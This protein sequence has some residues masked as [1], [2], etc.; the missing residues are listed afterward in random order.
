MFDK[1]KL[2]GTDTAIYGVSTI[3]GRFLTFLLTPIYANILPPSD[4]GIV[5]T[6]YAYIA[7]LS[8]LYT[9]GMESAYL[10]YSSTLELGNQKQTFTIPCLSLLVTSL[11]F[12]GLILLFPHPVAEA[13]HLP[14]SYERVVL[15]A[16]AILFLDAVVI[17][18]FAHLRM[19]RKAKMFATI[20]VVNIVINVSLNILFLVKYNLGV[21]G[22]FL[23][24]LL[25]SASSVVM[26]LPTIISNVTVKLP[27][28]LYGALLRFGLPYVPAGLATMMI[29]VVDRPILES[30]TDTATVGIYQANYR[31]GIFMMLIVSMFDFAWRPFFLT[32]AKDTDAKPLFAR[33]L[34]YFVL[35][36]SMV[37][38]VL[39][40]FLDDVIRWK[41]FWGHSILPEPYWP[42]LAIVPVILL[43]YMFLGVSNNLVAGI[44]IEKKTQHLPLVAFT[45]AFINVA[46]N[47][48]LIPPLGIMGAAVATL[49]SYAIMT[50]VLYFIVQRFYP[51]E[52]E[53]LR[54]AKIAFSAGVVFLVD[55]LVVFESFGLVWKLILLVLF[56]MLMYWMKFFNRSELNRFVSLFKRKTDEG[57]VPSNVLDAGV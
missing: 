36:T 6:V 56:V 27:A 53:W 9:Y 46:A 44:Y 26:L 21:E 11:F 20:K 29:Q 32:H 12:S 19:V 39:C 25:A 1:I 34:T 51:V 22:I 17:V 28:K 15:Y 57:Q 45:G 2:L 42:G 48:L 18:P 37:L 4:V 24:G 8:V 10:K 54:I 23:A 33:V 38:L 49:L 50:V 41:V 16:A 43:A 3:L 30:L 40:F 55:R 14:E 5:A 52:Y 13:I 47:F 7:F 35:V 31:L